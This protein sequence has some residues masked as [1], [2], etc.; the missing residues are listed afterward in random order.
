MES[1]ARI[2]KKLSNDVINLKK[3]A[4]KN[5]SRNIANPPFRR[6]GNPPTSKT[7]T[8]MEGA[9]LGQLINF[10]RTSN[11]NLD[12]TEVEDIDP[13]ANAEPSNEEKPKQ[14]SF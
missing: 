9:H 5:T 8:P 3:M 1:M 4:S 11:T 13:E 2:I 12:D 14:V 6:Y 10:I 7:L